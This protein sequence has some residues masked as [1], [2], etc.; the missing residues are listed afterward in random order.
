MLGV[1]VEQT[2]P[3]VCTQALIDEHALTHLPY[4]DWCET[5]VMRKAR[6]DA[7]VV[8]EHD[9]KQHSFILL[10]FGFASRTADDK[11]TVLYLQE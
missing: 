5:C 6:Q 2:K 9:R 10:D 8:Q 1:P 3:V 11:L 4:A 7:R